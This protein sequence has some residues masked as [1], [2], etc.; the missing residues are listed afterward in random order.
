MSCK[1]DHVGIVVNNLE[2][3]IKLYGDILGITPWSKGITNVPEAGLRQTQLRI[4]DS[5]IELIEAGKT[6]HALESRP[7]RCLRER[8]E[9]LFHITFFV[10]DY[11][12]RISDLKKKGFT[13][14]EEKTKKLFP[15]YTLRIAF[16]KPE[17]TRGVYIEFV[18]EKS[19]PEYYKTL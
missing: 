8:G 4:G 14:E 2:E 15:G 16:L 5:F 3:T 9:G 12:K 10:D 19:Q 18:D 17:Q 13:V 1:L 6:E 11:D 7:G